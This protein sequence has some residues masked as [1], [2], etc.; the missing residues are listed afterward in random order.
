MSPWVYVGLAALLLIGSQAVAAPT[1][2]A[3]FIAELRSVLNAIAP[4]LTPG[5]QQILIAH[6]A[7][8][9][10]WGTGRPARLGYNIFN[11]TRPKGDA[12]PVI[13]SGDHEC[14]ADG[15]C[16]PI[17]QRFAKYGSYYEAIAE[18]FRLLSTGRYST[19]LAR[20]EAGDSVG[21]VAKLREG[22]Y[23]TLPVADYQARF[24]GV[25]S[26]VRSRWAS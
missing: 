18:Y 5:A 6:A 10:G 13:E 19:A 2:P 24:A 23:Y 3:A 17:T 9:S 21:F 22:G 8:E 1:S 7:L 14:D 11:V 25:L 12:G 4:Y 16:R 26:S 15:N 20:L